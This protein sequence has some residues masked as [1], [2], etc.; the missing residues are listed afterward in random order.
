[1]TGW[2][3]LAISM[4]AVAVAAPA[5]SQD[6]ARGQ[7]IFKQCRACHA[8][9]PAARNKAGPQLNGI[10]GRKAGAVPGYTYSEAMTQAAA[11]GLVWTEPKLAAYLESPDAFLPQGVMEFAG[12]KN[13]AQLPDPL[14]LLDALK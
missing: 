2:V 9:G 10:V 1:M 7:E 6:P 3:R 13:L 8:V 11:G 14:A 4:A 12:V 5:W